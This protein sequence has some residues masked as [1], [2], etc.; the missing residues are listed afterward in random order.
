MKSDHTLKKLIYFLI[1]TSLSLTASAVE[2]SWKQQFADPDNEYKPKPLWFISGE[3]TT[4]E[5]RRQ[6]KEAKELAGFTGVSP[7]PETSVK[8]TPFSG[9]YY[10][11]YR[12]IVETAKELDMTVVLYD[13]V[14]FPSGSAG[15]RM[16]KLYPEHLQKRLEKTERMLKTHRGPRIFIDYVPRGELMSAVAMEK[17]SHELVDLRPFIKDYEL[18]WP[19]PKTPKEGEW[20]IMYFTVAPAHLS[21]NYANVDFM[22]SVALEKYMDLTYEEHTRQLG[23]YF[24]DTIKVSF[25]D[26]VGFWRN[27]AAWNATFNKKFIERHGFD[28]APYY[29][30]LWYDI[31]PDTLAMRYMFY[32]TR[33]EMLGEG[34]PKVVSEWAKRN[35][36]KD[37]GHPPA[38]WGAYPATINGDPFRFYRH[39]AIPLA[40]SIFRYGLGLDGFKLM[41]SIADYHDR[42]LVAVEIYGAFKDD[43]IDNNMLY[44]NVM[45]CYTRGI[46]LILPHAMWYKRG[47]GL[48]Y[49]SPLISP[50]NE[51][52]A[53]E[54]PNYS[55]YVGRCS[56]LLQGGRRVADVG[57]IY[58]YPDI[59]GSYPIDTSRDPK[60]KPFN[61]HMDLSKL[62]TR[63]LRRDFTFIHPDHLEEEKYSIVDGALRLNNETNFQNYRVLVLSSSKI[64]SR[65]TLETLKQFYESG[66]TVIATSILP[67]KSTEL[68]EDAKVVQ[69]VKELFGVDPSPDAGSKKGHA[70]TNPQGGRAVFVP[71]LHTASLREAFASSVPDVDFVSNIDLP[72]GVSHLSYIHKVKDGRDIYFFANST[73]AAVNADI[74]LR[75]DHKLKKWN[76]HTGETERVAQCETIDTN[77]MSQ[78]KIRLELAPVSSVFYVGE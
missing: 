20:Q 36:L 38:N 48:R 3:L 5:I 16:E 21:K 46:N 63:E 28:P 17:T 33:A 69:L 60:A 47:P 29:P 74:L 64:I 75:G 76:P 34:F 78:T 51:K 13:D 23:T 18:R 49:I 31:G 4:D 39:T 59:A 45:N 58:P 62:L 22:D 6:L 66:G 42:P 9:E 11:R 12:D 2:K 35:G 72:R 54:L 70:Q 71:K 26:D 32:D 53:D 25:F 43:I 8:P 56:F 52:I 40:D 41:S 14:S 7:L 73:D 77:G 55:E 50:E 65:K 30:V 10:D 1:I 57:L 44:R 15:G 24:G 37:T 68:G 19:V 27:P 61:D 67:Y